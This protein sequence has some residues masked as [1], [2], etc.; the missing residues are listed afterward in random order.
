MEESLQPEEP[1]SSRLL[2]SDVNKL[3]TP[4]FVFFLFL[5]VF[6]TLHI[7][8]DWFQGKRWNEGPWGR[9]RKDPGGGKQHL[10]LCQPQY[11]PVSA[12]QMEKLNLADMK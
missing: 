12:L 8:Y 7:P 5:V 10:T 11:D 9:A 1:Q 3:S 2:I 4:V 6:K